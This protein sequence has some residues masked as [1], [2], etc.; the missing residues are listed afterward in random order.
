M[1]EPEAAMTVATTTDDVDL[2]SEERVRLAAALSLRRILEQLREVFEPAEGV[3]ESALQLRGVVIEAELAQLQRLEHEAPPQ[4]FAGRFARVH[5]ATSYVL[6][7]IGRLNTQ[8][9]RE[10]TLLVRA[11]ITR[12]QA[13]RAQHAVYRLALENVEWGFSMI[14]TDPDLAAFLWQGAGARSRRIRYACR[15]LCALLEVRDRRGAL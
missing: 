15:V 12:P 13:L 10:Q 14:G 2:A 3:R 7:L 6:D 8:L 4:M 9:V 1:T 11:A 5:E